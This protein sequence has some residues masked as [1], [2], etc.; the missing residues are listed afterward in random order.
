M[1]TV[2]PSA[3]ECHM[4]NANSIS[5]RGFREQ[6]G[7]FLETRGPRCYRLWENGEA[8]SLQSFDSSFLPHFSPEI[9]VYFKCLYC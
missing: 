6:N 5:S 9:L 1:E 3:H 2:I 7:L 8:K 4:P